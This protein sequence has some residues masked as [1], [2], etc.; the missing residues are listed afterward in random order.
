MNHHDQEATDFSAN[1]AGYAFPEADRE[2]V[3]RAIFQRRD[4]RNFR[5]DPIPDETLSRIIRAA[6][7]GP[8]VGFMQPGISSW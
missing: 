2:A 7:H 8:S 5:P 1:G 3:Y 6:H 4:I